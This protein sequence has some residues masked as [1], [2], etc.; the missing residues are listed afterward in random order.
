MTE[1]LV[2]NSKIAK[3]NNDKFTVY[4]FGIPAYQSASGLKT[5]P[6]AGQCAKGCYAQAG[7]YVWS[8]VKAAYEWRL[9]QSLASGFVIDMVK[10][11]QVKY[12]TSNRQGKILVIRIHDSGDFYNLKY[13]NKWLEIM[14]HFPE[15][16]YNIFF[17]AYTKQ[18]KLFNALKAQYLI[19]DNFHL[20]YSE[21]GIFDNLIDR[22]KDRHSRVFSNMDD[23]LAA[24][25]KNAT[26]NDLVAIEPGIKIGLVYHGVNSKAWSTNNVA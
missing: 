1:L 12:K 16:S 6:S 21:G 5:C 17:Y 8:G 15:S 11:I 13:T 3:A 25:Y 4:N 10:A 20:I 26:E 14:K 22:T 9:A 18:V 7:A 24:G 23:L 2:K 19:P